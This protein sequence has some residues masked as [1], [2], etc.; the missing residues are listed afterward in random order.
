MTCLIPFFLFSY[1]HENFGLNKVVSI[2]HSLFLFLCDFTKVKGTCT[3]L[4]WV[5]SQIYII[6]KMF[7]VQQ[8]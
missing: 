8:S 3:T 7:G 2:S 4:V 6:S 1:V 5:L